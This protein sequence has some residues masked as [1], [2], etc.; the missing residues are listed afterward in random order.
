MN[1]FAQVYGQVR[2]RP[3]IRFAAGQIAGRG[4]GQRQVCSGLS[5]DHRSGLVPG[6]GEVN[7]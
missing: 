6:H 7:Q 2:S 4:S 5:E 3:V 1:I